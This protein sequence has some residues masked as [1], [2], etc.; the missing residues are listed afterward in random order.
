MFEIGQ[1]VNEENYT[2]AAIWCNQNGA[3]IEKQ[4]GVYVIVQNAPAPEPTYAE[5]RAAQYP[6][7]AE[8]MD[9]IYWDRVNG[10]NVWEETV[11]AVKAKYPKPQPEEIG[12]EDLPETEKTAGNSTDVAPAEQTEPALPLDEDGQG[13]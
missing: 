4:N 11:A 9:M 2:D 13:A 5:K 8:Q 6:S 7:L 1:I 12:G 10:T 3:H